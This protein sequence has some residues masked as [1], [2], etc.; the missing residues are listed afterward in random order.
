MVLHEEAWGALAAS[1]RLRQRRLLRLLDELRG[2]PFRSGDFREVD[3]YGRANEVLLVDEWLVTFWCD[4][5]AREIR[6]VRLE[7][8]DED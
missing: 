1:A 5:A 8:A 3:A 6:I 7:K 4:H 2:D